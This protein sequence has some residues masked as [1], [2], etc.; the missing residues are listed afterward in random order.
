MT[1][2][3]TAHNT[4]LDM[5]PS[6]GQS[7]ETS[8]LTVTDNGLRFEN[9]SIDKL[10]LI[11][12]KPIKYNEFN[13]TLSG[14]L[15]IGL[16][17]EVNGNVSFSYVN[18]SRIVE[19]MWPFMAISQNWT[20]LG[21]LMDYNEESQ[22]LRI[23]KVVW[24]RRPIFDIRFLLPTQ[25]EP[26]GH[27]IQPIVDI[28][29]RKPLGN[30]TKQYVKSIFSK[31]LYRT[32]NRY[33]HFRRKRDIQGV[34][35]E[36]TH[37]QTDTH[38][39]KHKSDN[40]GSRADADWKSAMEVPEVETELEHN[41][42]TG[43]PET[44]QESHTQGMKTLDLI[45]INL[46]RFTNDTTLVETSEE[47]SVETSVES[48][49]SEES[50]AEGGAA[51]GAVAGG[52][53]GGASGGGAAGKASGQ[54]AGAGKGGASGGG[55]G[56]GQAGG[57]AIAGGGG[58]GQASGKGGAMQAGGGSGK[59][60]QGGAMMAGGGS[61]Q[62]GGMMASG[63]SA[64]GQ[65]GGAMMAGGGSGQGGG[66]GGGKS[67]GASGQASG[68]S[69]SGKAG[70]GS[71]SGTGKSGS[72]QSGSSQSGQAS[73]G[74][75]QSSSY[76]ETQI[77]RSGGGQAGGS[78][79]VGVGQA[80]GG[81]SGGGRGGG[82]SG[83]GGGGAF[84]DMVQPELETESEY[85]T[86]T[87]TPTK[88]RTTHH[89]TTKMRTTTRKPT[90]HIA[91]TTPIPLTLCERKIA[92]DLLQLE[93]TDDYDSY[94]WHQMLELMKKE[95]KKDYDEMEAYLKLKEKCVHSA[96]LRHL[97]HTT[98]AGAVAGSGSKTEAS[99]DGEC[100][101]SQLVLLIYHIFN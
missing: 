83:G 11:V 10:D 51:G 61:S 60:G 44:E 49:V 17:F 16:G 24:K 21:F 42:L 101:F 63:G 96:T 69:G 4:T 87:G 62:S 33:H 77:S 7:V 36:N 12:M 37:Y 29:M 97:H 54:A 15:R 92:E 56:G 71:V 53:G 72:S 47:Q 57:A 90:T 100:L 39:A 41:T 32:M 52:G 59:A 75:V 55:A 85:N 27:Q 68:G 65:S 94:A 3:Y 58:A 86:L 5:T 50:S 23:R 8:V 95:C 34:D 19:G 78:Q 9:A 28:E 2:N 13:R 30:L 1:T 35:Q 82:Q 46:Q 79:V 18:G 98:V 45:I 40:V 38:K 70:G 48:S 73:G 43:A 80:G 67:G 93:I 26:I 25:L 81:Q 84:G 6:E 66:A 20:R 89:A 91:T 99:N 76:Q 64:S 22:T 74:S 88:H 14:E 31:P